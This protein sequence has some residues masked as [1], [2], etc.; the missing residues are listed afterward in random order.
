MQCVFG[1]IAYFILN[2]C[3]GITYAYIP[4]PIPLLTFEYQLCIDK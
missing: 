1:H 2:I 3:V 4:V